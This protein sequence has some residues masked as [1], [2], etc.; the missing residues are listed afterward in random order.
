LGSVYRLN[1]FYEWEIFYYP[2]LLE[3]SKELKLKAYSL[4]YLFIPLLKEEDELVLSHSPQ[5]DFLDYSRQK[6][7]KDIQV[8]NSFKLNKEIIEWGRFHK[9]INGRLEIDIETVLFHKKL[10]SKLFQDKFRQRHFI[11]CPK[12]TRISRIQTI[13]KFIEKFGF[14]FSIKPEFGLSGVLS[15]TIYNE[16]QLKENH[17][18]IQSNILRNKYFI[19]S[20]KKRIFDFS[21]LFDSSS[22]LLTLTSMNINSNGIY[23]GSKLLN[24]KNLYNKMNL[25]YNILQSQKILPKGAFSIDAFLY[26]ENELVK[27]CLLSEINT[28]WTMGR[29]LYEI[30]K[31]LQVKEL[32]IE[33]VKNLWKKGMSILD[34]ETELKENLKANILTI[35]TPPFLGS[36]KI[37]SICVLF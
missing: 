6:W 8:T 25:I 12:R 18:K 7:N 4:E 36:Q 26:K 15:W 32:K 27:E 10:S 9:F 37:S 34:L 31:I 22:G 23:K 19:E 33:F 21:G 20:W 2:K 14:P 3:I 29:I 16:R 28:R 5:K 30:T 1:P 24:D 17:L 35:L 11:D 13:Y